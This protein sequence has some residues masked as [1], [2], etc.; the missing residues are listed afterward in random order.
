MTM[1]THSEKKTDRQTA[2]QT[3]RFKGQK[4]ASQATAGRVGSRDRY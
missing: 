2:T 4:T 3:D 1:I